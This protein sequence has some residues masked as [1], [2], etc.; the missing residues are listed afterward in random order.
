MQRF[1]LTGGIGTG[2]ST[3][4]GILVACGATLVDT[5]AIAR[6]LTQAGGAA[7]PS[8]QSAF[9]SAVVDGSGALDRARMRALAFSDDNHRAR[10]ESILHP[11][12]GAECD[13][14]AEAAPGRAVVFD[15]PLLVESK[16][17]RPRVERVLVIDAPENVQ[18]E[19]VMARSGWTRDMV[20]AVMA[21]QV[22]RAV[23]LRAAD[24]VIYNAGKT[25]AELATEV[26]SLWD[27]WARSATR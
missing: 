26:Q 5:D 15:V 19:R 10:L 22:P 3:V 11:L 23:R 1:G 9:G 20:L 21:N 14:Q 13:R 8:I 27:R 17:W 7:M 18:V 4:A 2:K 24:G 12:I 16:R 6:V 25:L